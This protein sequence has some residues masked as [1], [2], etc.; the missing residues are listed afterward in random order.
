MF[1]AGM[2]S[3]V[4]LVLLVWSP[5]THQ[6]VTLEELDRQGLAEYGAGWWLVKPVVMGAPCPECPAQLL[7]IKQPSAPTAV[8]V[9]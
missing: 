1:V 2:L 9:E 8:S 4:A 3:A 7:P 6:L 5:W